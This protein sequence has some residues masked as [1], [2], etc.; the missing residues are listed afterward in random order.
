MTEVVVE[1][2]DLVGDQQALFPAGR[3]IRLLDQYAPQATRDQDLILGV[4]FRSANRVRYKLPDYLSASRLP[5]PVSGK[6]AF[7]TYNVQFKQ[8]GA[9]L[10]MEVSYDIAAERIKVADYAAF[11]AWLNELDRALNQPILLQND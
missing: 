4:P 10:E 1:G 7:G 2:L 5:Q 8:D 3:E 11:R 6:S 9:T